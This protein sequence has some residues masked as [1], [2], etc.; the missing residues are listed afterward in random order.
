MPVI[1]A[2]SHIEWVR[3]SE[4]NETLGT[5][6]FP[7]MGPKRLFKTI[8]AIITEMLDKTCC[9]RLVSYPLEMKR[10]PLFLGGGLTAAP[11]H[12]CSDD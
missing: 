2:L 7:G 9:R 10:N 12:S 8:I 4:D 1:K 5:I 6:G 11:A 3:R